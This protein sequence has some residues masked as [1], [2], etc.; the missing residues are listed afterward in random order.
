MKQQKAFEGGTK[1]Y[2]KPYLVDVPVSINIW[3]R[4]ECQQKQFKIIRQARPSI[5]FVTSDGGRN[6]QEWK[7]IRQNRKLYED[8]IDWDCTVYN[9]YE[10]KNN[11]M[12]AMMKIRHD[13]IWSRV[14]RCIFLEDDH[15]PS[16]SFFRFCA[17][18]LE[19]YKDDLRVYMICGMNQLGVRESVNADYFF[20]RAGSIWGIATWKRCYKQYGDFSYG[21]DHYVMDCLKRVTRKD[22]SMWNSIEAYAKSKFY[23]GHPAGDEFYLGFAPYGQ[24]QVLIIPKYNMIS[25]MGCTVDSAHAGELRTLPRG[26]RRVFDMRTY[27]IGFP[28]KHPK[29]VVPDLE[30]ERRIKRILGIGH[31]MVNAWRKMERAIL[32]IR[33][34]GLK[35]MLGK[36]SAV[37]KRTKKNRQTE[38]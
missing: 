36:L 4:P 24:N 6:E 32:I 19:K 15:I 22:K 27:E 3:I 25:N 34:E 20:S 23:K 31:P 29:Y 7:I 33:Y 17:D 5:L 21:N 37:L 9:V 2:M 14:D 18:L 26:I 16:I 28:L 10:E 1:S 35:S 8:G 30:Y 12:Y 38:K 11:G 13:F